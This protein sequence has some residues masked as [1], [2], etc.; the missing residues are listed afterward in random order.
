MALDGIYIEDGNGG[1]VFR[2]VGQ[3]T[4]A[5]VARVADR[6][7]RCVMHLM[8]Q[9]G[10]GRQ[11]DPEEADTLRRDEPLLAELYSASITGRVATGPRAGKRIVRIGDEVDS[12]NA[13][14]KSGR[15]CTSIEGFSVHAGVCVPARDRIR[16]ERLL[17]YAARPP[18]S[19]ERL[20]LLPDGKLLYQ[21]KRRWSDGTT[22]VSY[23]PMELIE[24]LAALVPPPR[25]NITR[26]YVAHRFM[27]S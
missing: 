5:E 12:E 13:L 6:V 2:A 27:W 4:V 23:E 7:H 25:F 11:A 17:R 8:A 26:Y 22:H 15:C 10:L 20:S 16:L 3:P 14:M 18:L 24:R 21:L 9:R 1:P 19:N